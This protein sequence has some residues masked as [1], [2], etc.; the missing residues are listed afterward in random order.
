MASHVQRQISASEKFGNA[1]AI[2]KTVISAL[3]TLPTVSSATNGANWSFKRKAIV[4]FLWNSTI[5]NRREALLAASPTTGQAIHAE[6]AECEKFGFQLSTTV[7][8]CGSFPDATL[9][10]IQLPSSSPPGKGEGNVFLYFHGGGYRN[11]IVGTGHVP[12]VLEAA[13][14][15][16]CEKVIFLEYTLT[17]RMQYPGQLVQ[18]AYALKTMLERGLRPE[19]IIV[20]GDSAGGNLALA[21][22]AH[23]KKPL[24]EA[25]LVEGFGEGGKLRG[26]VL[27]SPWVSNTTHASSFTE[28]KHK[29]YISSENMHI[30]VDLWRPRN[31]IY[32]DFI[33]A[34]GSRDFWDSV[35]AEKMFIVA[36]GFEA[37]RDDIRDVAARLERAM[38]EE[39]RFVE[40]EG[41]VHVQCVV[42][43]ASGEMPGRSHAALMKWCGEL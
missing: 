40:A 25:P 6:C 22:L 37:L 31:E 21:L 36:G 8:S 10:E 20:G 43:V 30:F 7:I 35:P 13:R 26:V 41:E 9:H 16:E 15:A 42:D 39:L 18:A 12:L 24:Q 19:N 28:N 11:P 32:A 34:P 1:I 14:A 27:L 5:L 4:S 17:L 2:L 38:G 23:L 33:N 3:I 29:D